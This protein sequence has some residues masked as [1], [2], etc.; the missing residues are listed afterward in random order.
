MLNIVRMVGQF[1]YPLD[2]LSRV[3]SSHIR[4]QMTITLD[5]GGQTSWWSSILGG[6]MSMIV[7][8]RWW[9]DFHALGIWKFC[10]SLEPGFQSSTCAIPMGP[11]PCNVRPRNYQEWPGEYAKFLFW[12]RWWAFPMP[13]C[14]PASFNMFGALCVGCLSRI[15]LLD[16][17]PGSYYF[18]VIDI[19]I[20]ITV[21]TVIIILLII[22][23]NN[24]PWFSASFSS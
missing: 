24:S 9:F 1:T 16:R 4:I 10:G 6:F 17:W 19:D 23:S 12:E 20:V 22:I 14:W 7:Y 2:H 15:C 3:A 18:P 5:F 13:C 11:L 21:I 8:L